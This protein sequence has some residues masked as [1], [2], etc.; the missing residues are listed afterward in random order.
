[1]SLRILSAK[2]QSRETIL[3]TFN[4]RADRFTAK[5]FSVV[6]GVKI[7]SIKKLENL[8]SLHTTPIDIKKNYTVIVKSIGSVSVF[9]DGIFDE[10]VSSK[11]LGC[12]QE[13]GS[14]IFR[15]FAPREL[16]VLVV[17]YS[18]L[19]DEIGTSFEMYQDENGVWE[20]SLES[21]YIGKYYCFKV[22]CQSNLSDTGDCEIAIADPY[23]RAV[24]RKNN[25][26]HD[27]KSLII[28]SQFDWEGDTWVAIK[29]SDLIIYEM[30][31]QDMTA[32]EISGVAENLKGT[33]L[34]LIQKNST[35]GIDYIKSLGVNAIELLPSQEFATFE[36]P[37][38]QLA[39]GS[40][41]NTWNPYERNYWGY[42]TSCYFAPHSYYASNARV[43]KD[44]WNDTEG[45][46]VSEFK[47]MVK[48]F[49][50]EGIAVIMDVVYNHTSQYDHQPLKY[51]D[52]YYYYH[53]DD[54]GKYRSTSG[55]GNDFHTSRPM[56][57]R[58]IIDSLI[59]WMTEYHVDGFRFDLATM[60]DW[61]TFEEI[62][63]KTRAINPNVILIAEPWGGGEY[64]LTGFSERGAA[65]W[66]D[67][68][69]NEV[70]G[71]NPHNARG[72]IFGVW[73]SSVLESFRKWV[74]GST[75]K[76][77]GGFL[78]PFH[79]VNYLESHDGF[80]LGDFIRIASGEVDESTTITD[81]DEHVQLTPRQLR[82]AKFAA[83]MLMVCKGIVMM[84][85]GQEF[86]RTKV[87]APT[88]LPDAKNG[89]LDSNSYEKNDETNWINYH[90]AEINRDLF[91]Y[92]KGMIEVRSAFPELRQSP[93]ENYEFFSG[94]H[95]LSCGFVLRSIQTKEQLLIVLINSSQTLPAQFQ[96]PDGMWS[97]IVD[98]GLAGID[99]IRKGTAQKI[100]IP[101]T[102]GM[103]LV[104]EYESSYG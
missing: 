85:A 61:D 84:Q 21:T 50:R 11:P 14:Y 40:L 17:T 71:H 87:I 78:D 18:S 94:S 36:P 58:L 88:S 95:P 39:G 23:S 51:I 15:L 64:D 93:D 34:G 74:L 65:A 48:A 19:D 22:S 46:Q 67:I 41:Y 9:P 54:H 49:H 55:C 76:Y 60:I 70:K 83:F 32:H 75:Q 102:S 90:H 26:V 82:F 57:R 35:C 103:I 2:I 29:P 13:N 91:E 59:H 4:Q 47:E 30:H 1:M 81:V 12:T 89:K 33:Y 98:D 6:P 45:R 43:E 66:N 37:Y 100:T 24:V 104:K 101:T 80:T 27:S 56:S 92:Y 96:L 77:G 8:I 7:T 31:I 10:F 42:M 16:S 44:N 53:I 5:D 73:Q 97:V 99:I 63:E 20:I 68:F 25:Y 72:F 69:R 3:L 86:A 79:S 52:K 38:K 28:D 62:I